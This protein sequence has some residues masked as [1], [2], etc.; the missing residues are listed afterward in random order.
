[1]KD[2]YYGSSVVRKR[3]TLIQNFEVFC[4]ANSC[5]K[6]QNFCVGSGKVAKINPWLNSMKYF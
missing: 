2:Y 1:M 4:L 5:Q 6:G 3:E